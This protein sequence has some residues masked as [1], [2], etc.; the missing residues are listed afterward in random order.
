VAKYL[1]YI[2]KYKVRAISLVK[3]FCK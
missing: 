2:K 1:D 3:V